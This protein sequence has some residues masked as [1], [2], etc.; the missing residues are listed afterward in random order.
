METRRQRREHERRE[1]K[2]AIQAARV[3]G[4]ES[5]ERF[6][7]VLALVGFALGLA[8]WGWSVIAPN[9]SAIFGSILFFLA[10][11]AM[12]AAIRRMWSL[13]KPALALV[14]IVA[15]V[16]F[17]TFDWYI[18]IKPQRGKPF[19]ALLVHGYHLTSECGS[20]TGT[21]QMPTWMR[22]ESKEWQA[23]A[24]QLITEKLA[25]K[26]SQLW[27]GAV[28][29][30]RVTDENT[31]AYQC[32]WLANK[33]GALE[34]IISAEYDPSLKHRDYNGPTYWFEPV[35]GKVDISD[36]FKGGKQ[37]ANIVIGG[38]ATDDQ[39]QK[40]GESSKR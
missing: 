26:D 1:A 40:T 16:G 27:Q 35:N 33:V 9:S 37:Q 15:M 31:V 4:V 14:A 25:A 17:I 34:T 5:K 13:G 36:A 38:T 22:D 11:V 19:Q 7:E 21:Q 2:L 6:S 24:E 28:I 18:I 23:Q 8:S 30:G 39:Q 20:L 32:T 12:V 29:Y 10:V 3:S